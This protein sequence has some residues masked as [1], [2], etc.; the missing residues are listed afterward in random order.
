MLIIN[1]PATPW[2]KSREGNTIR[3]RAGLEHCI[4][5]Y[6]YK[7]VC[8]CL[9]VCAPAA[10][11]L[12]FP[13]ATEILKRCVFVIPPPGLRPVFN[14]LTLSSISR[15]WV[16]LSG[17]HSE[18]HQAQKANQKATDSNFKSLAIQAINYVFIELHISTYYGYNMFSI[19][20]QSS[21][22]WLDTFSWTQLSFVEKQPRWRVMMWFLSL[23]ITIMS[24]SF[25]LYLSI[26]L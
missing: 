26:S 2:L 21:A 1:A 13:L 17:S 3:I 9:C 4:P 16:Q 14:S 20:V 7:S 18:W 24:V 8:L 15:K 12:P 25:V 22:I 10:V 19:C 6:V 11:T 23:S 5:L